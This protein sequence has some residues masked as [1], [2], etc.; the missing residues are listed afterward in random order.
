MVPDFHTNGVL[1]VMVL[2]T[3]NADGSVKSAVLEKSS[4]NATADAFTLGQAEG[5]IYEPKMVSCKPVE[6]TYLFKIIW[7]PI[8]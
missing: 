1:V 4:H 7:A 3:V 6:G 2:V 5:G 8:D